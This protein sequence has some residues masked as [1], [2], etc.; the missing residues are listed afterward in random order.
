MRMDQYYQ[1]ESEEEEDEEMEMDEVPIKAT[2]FMG[3]TINTKQQPT[4]VFRRV[5]NPAPAP[6]RA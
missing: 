6:V 3:R 5:Q 2:K 1:E 4:N